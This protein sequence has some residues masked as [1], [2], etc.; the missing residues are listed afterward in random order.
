MQNYGRTKYRLGFDYT[1]HPCDIV[2]DKDEIMMTDQVADGAILGEDARHYAGHQKYAS[3]MYRGIV[4]NIGSLKQ[5]GRFLE[6]G[7]GPG[8]L[9]VMLAKKYSDI[10]ITLVDFSPDMA[11]VAVE[12]IGGSG[13]EKGRLHYIVGDVADTA[14]MQELGTYDCVF[15]TFSLHHWSNPEVSLINLWRAVERGGVLYIHDFRRIGWLA[16]LLGSGGLGKSVRSSFTPREL[17]ALLENKV[18]IKDV[19]VETRLHSPFQT[20]IA[21]KM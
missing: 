20:V 6:M 1:Q 10:D 16:A 19:R 3:I 5:N 11:D 17:K 18:G 8:F 4:D 9:A 12:Y 13:I 15:T 7:A 14:F 21:R 2:I